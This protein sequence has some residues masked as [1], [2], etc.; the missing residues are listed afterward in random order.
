MSLPTI[1]APVTAQESNLIL[2]VGGGPTRD[3]SLELSLYAILLT[4][5]N[6]LILPIG[7]A[8][9]ITRT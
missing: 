9:A 4:G 8:V 2:G 5:L 6:W 3:Q 7:I 1:D